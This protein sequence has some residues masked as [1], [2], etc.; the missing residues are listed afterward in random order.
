MATKGLTTEEIKYIPELFEGIRYQIEGLLKER[1]HDIFRELKSVTSKA[2]ETGEDC[3]KVEIKLKTSL[4]SGGIVCGYKTALEYVTQFKVK[5]ESCIETFDPLN[6]DLFDKD[7]NPNPDITNA[8]PNAYANAE[9]LAS[10]ETL[11]LGEGESDDKNGE[12]VDAELIE[13]D[14][15]DTKII[16]LCDDCENTYPECDADKI[17]FG[18]GKGNDNVIECDKFTKKFPWDKRNEAL[19]LDLDKELK[20]IKKAVEKAGLTMGE[21]ET[22][23]QLSGALGPQQHLDDSPVT[24]KYLVDNISSIIKGAV[25]AFRKKINDEEDMI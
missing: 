11:L 23:L 4:T 24:I 19:E 2:V 14:K 18:D 5:D 7:G 15:N 6:P 16:H 3:G 22:H 21:L 25:E 17:V 12:I 9:K 13:D 8:N 20:K 10:G 1:M